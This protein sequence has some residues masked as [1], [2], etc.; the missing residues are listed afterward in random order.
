MAR[1]VL[2]LTNKC[3]FE[4]KACLRDLSNPRE[5]PFYL[6]EKAISESKKYNID[7]VALTGGEPFLYTNFVKLVK[8]IVKHDLK[9]SLVSNGYLFKEFQGILNQYKRRI[10]VINFSFESTKEELHDFLRKKGS[11]KKLLSAFEFCK[12][13]K[14]PFST[15]STINFKNYEE[16]QDIAEF[17]RIKGASTMACTTTLPCPRANKHKL[18]L[19]AGKRKELYYLLKGISKKMNFP[20]GI[21]TDIY[22]VLK[23][24]ICG[25][26]NMYD[27][28]I[29][30]DGDF[31]FCCELSGYDSL[32]KNSGRR[33]KV[34]SLKRY[35]LKECL[36]FYA[37]KIQEFMC[38]RIDEYSSKKNTYSPDFNS[39]FYCIKKIYGY[40]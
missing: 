34:A 14:I 11:F 4:C 36:K 13:N 31:T 26:S 25:V 17:I 19:N 6:I 27:F 21:S 40:K 37:G 23:P 39:C 10:R 5:L 18:V 1:L 24:Y 3:N 7:Y 29:D 15:V 9:F 2:I 33:I 30:I 22:G 12:K 28:T 38:D 8:L 35:S 20:I 16:I 32:L